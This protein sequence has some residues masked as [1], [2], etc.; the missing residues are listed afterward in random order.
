MHR[1]RLTLAA[2]LALVIGVP[3]VGH[4]SNRPA[5]TKG[6]VVGLGSLWIDLAARVDVGQASIV[7]PGPGASCGDSP[8][9]QCFR[10]EGEDT[11]QIELKDDSDA[12]IAGSYSF[13][14]GL[15]DLGGGGFCGSITVGVPNEATKVIVFVENDLCDAIP[16]TGTI[17][18]T[19][20][21]PA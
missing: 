12:T 3:V 1:H 16:T 18:V 14:N 5:E 21:P 2:A 20:D 4:T 8:V 17:T 15:V 7:A 10:L 9:A 6:Y 13:R 11:I 19:Y